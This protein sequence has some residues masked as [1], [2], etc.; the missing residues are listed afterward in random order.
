MENFIIIAVLLCIIA[1]IVFYLSRAKKRGEA[2]IGCPYS[3]QCGSKGGSESGRCGISGGRA[4]AAAGKV[5]LRKGEPIISYAEKVDDGV[6]VS[7]IEKAGYTV[8]EINC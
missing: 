7:R 1:A 4:G 5:N 8:T 3:R 2:C 6:I